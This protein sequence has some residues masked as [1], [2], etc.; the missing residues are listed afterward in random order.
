MGYRFLQ[1][2]IGFEAPKFLALVFLEFREF[3]EL[4]IF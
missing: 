3:G 2:T 1:F 4:E